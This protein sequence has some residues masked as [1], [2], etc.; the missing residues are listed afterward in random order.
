MLNQAISSG[1][2]I[3]L[4]EFANG[5]ASENLNLWDC[6]LQWRTQNTNY[7]RAFNRSIATI[8]N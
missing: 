1:I 4:H 7:N 8:F 3:I 5:D 6:S 2:E